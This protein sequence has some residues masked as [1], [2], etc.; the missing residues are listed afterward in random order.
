ML[1]GAP[2]VPPAV[3]GLVMTGVEGAMLK[4]TTSDPV[5]VALVAATVTLLV[6]VAVGVPEITP[7]LAFKD[8]PVGK[9]PALILKLVG[10]LVAVI[11]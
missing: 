1:M 9:V 4:D 2:V 6:P 10:L 3:F 8:K 5:P 11:V 7:V